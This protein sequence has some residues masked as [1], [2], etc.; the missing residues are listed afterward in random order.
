[1]SPIS[2]CKSRPCLL[3]CGC[4]YGPTLSEPSCLQKEEG[5]FEALL[6]FPCIEKARPPGHWQEG[7]PESRVLGGP[8]LG[9]GLGKRL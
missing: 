1:M 5:S 7:R 3:L 4:E 8:S 2:G 6:V 9:H